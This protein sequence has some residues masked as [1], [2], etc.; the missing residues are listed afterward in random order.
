MKKERRGKENTEEI[1]K[2]RKMDAPS[3]NCRAQVLQGF[4]LK[5]GRRRRMKE[6]KFTDSKAVVGAARNAVGRAQALA[7]SA[8][9]A[10]DGANMLASQ[11]MGKGRPDSRKSRLSSR[12]NV[13]ITLVKKFGEVGLQRYPTLGNR[14][15]GGKMR[16]AIEKRSEYRKL[17]G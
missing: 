9:L 8:V 3:I 10:H 16:Q 1:L 14:Q 2:K 5:P 4:L 15:R 12:L 13:K 6:K 7:N 17:S 11:R